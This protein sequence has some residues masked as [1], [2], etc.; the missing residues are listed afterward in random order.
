[1]TAF[2]VICVL[3]CFFVITSAFKKA[4]TSFLDSI[5]PRMPGPPVKRKR[6]RSQRHVHHEF[7]SSGHRK[8]ILVHN[9]GFLEY[10]FG[11]LAVD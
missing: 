7:R 2:K 1:M 3:L 11:S 6:N 9:H 10:S 4:T 8:R 5:E